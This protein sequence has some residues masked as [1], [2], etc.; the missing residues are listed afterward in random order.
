SDHVGRQL[1]RGWGPGQALD[2]L[3]HHTRP[4]FL[5]VNLELLLAQ[6]G[7]ASRAGPVPVGRPRRRVEHH[8]PEQGHWKLAVGLE[9]LQAPIGPGYAL[10]P[11]GASK[12]HIALLQVGR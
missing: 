2:E 9:M 8:L 7:V 6:P 10:K 4:Y 3:P 12:P 1:L 11:S 5:D